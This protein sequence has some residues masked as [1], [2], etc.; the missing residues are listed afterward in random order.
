[1]YLQYFHKSN[2]LSYFLIISLSLLLSTKASASWRV[3]AHEH[4]SCSLESKVV[5][6]ETGRKLAYIGV[7]KLSREQGEKADDLV[8]NLFVF[9]SN[10]VMETRSRFNVEKG[11]GVQL[12]SPSISEYLDY[13]SVD[14]KRKRFN[15]YSGSRRVKESVIEALLKGEDITI[16]FNTSSYQTRYGILSS[17]KFTKSYHR[18][19]DCLATLE[20][21]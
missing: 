11:V 17:K 3:K 16:E 9:D 4:K 14:D 21:S 20:D 6:K 8:R 2:L 5:D 19:E 1:M 15:L 12:T 7:M 18:F 10:L 13:V